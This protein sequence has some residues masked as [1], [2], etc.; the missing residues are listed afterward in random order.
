[1][2][3][4]H[5]AFYG[6][7][8]GQEL[9]LAQDGWPAT[10]SLAPFTTALLLGLHPRGAL[11]IGDRIFLGP[12]R[13]DLDNR[14]VCFAGRLFA[15]ATAPPPAMRRAD[16]VVRAVFGLGGVGVVTRRAVAL[17]VSS[18]GRVSRAVGFVSRGLG[19]SVAVT[20]GGGCVG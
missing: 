20:G 15:T 6:F 13:A 8:A 11:H 3:D 14:A 19:F 10:A 1:M 9:R 17:V 4:G 2:P 7:P 12:R 16:L 18:V 5:D